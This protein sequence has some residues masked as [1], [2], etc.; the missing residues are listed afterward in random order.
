MQSFLE[1]LVGGLTGALIVEIVATIIWFKN[2]KK[3]LQVK[4]HE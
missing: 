4:K 2:L 1:G 3:S